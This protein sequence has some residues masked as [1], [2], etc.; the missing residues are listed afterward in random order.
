VPIPAVGVEFVFIPG[1]KGEDG[2]ESYPAANRAEVSEGVRSA[3][4]ELDV[5][6]LRALGIEG[7]GT[8]ARS[9]AGRADTTCR[10]RCKGLGGEPAPSATPEADDVD[11]KVRARGKAYLAVDP[12]EG[13]RTVFEVEVVDLE[14]GGE[15]DLAFA[16]ELVDLEFEFAVKFARELGRLRPPLGKGG[17]DFSL[18]YFIPDPFTGVVALDNPS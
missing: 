10:G 18:L 12:S 8:A 1:G 3:P 7:T 9:P 17:N 13:V 4:L 2:A 6:K 16:V 15:V 14:F 5:D 11:E